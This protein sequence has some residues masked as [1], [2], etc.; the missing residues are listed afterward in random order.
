MH[1]FLGIN[2]NPI[3]VYRQE[4]DRD[5]PDYEQWIM[6]YYNKLKAKCEKKLAEDYLKNLGTNLFKEKFSHFFEFQR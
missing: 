1:E 2:L 3:T 4:D 5:K 6:L